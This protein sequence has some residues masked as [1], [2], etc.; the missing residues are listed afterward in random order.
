M[1]LK[2]IGGGLAG[3]EAA[4]QAA[5]RGVQV[6]LF[7]MRPHQ[8]T[9]AHRTGNLA[10]LV[11]SNSLGSNLTNRPAGL[12]KEEL[13]RLGSLLISSADASSLPAGGAL[14]VDRDLFA[15]II[16]EK[17]SSHPNITIVREEIREI[18]AAPAIIATGPL[19]SS[20]LAQSILKFTGEDQL[21]FYDAIAPVITRES[22][23]ME[24]AF[25]ANRYA[26]GDGGEGDYINCPL[27]KDQYLTFREALIH[28]KRIPLRE[29][30]KEIE[31]GV[32]A[33]EQ[34][35]FQA[36]QPIEVIAG[37]GE[38]ALAF[39]PLR[40]VGLFDPHSNNKRP[41]AVVQLRQEN[42]AGDL[43]N[44]VG[45]QTN[46]TYSEQAKVFKMIPGLENAAFERFGQ[47]HRNTYL[48]GPK[49]LDESLA[50]KNQPG[51]F[52]AGQ[53]AGFEGYA[54]N[55]AAGLIAGINATNYIKG[56]PLLK[57]PRTTMIGALVHYVTHAEA[58]NFQPT[59]AMFG[60]LPKPED[61]LRRKKI[62]RY[63]FYVERA[64]KH[65]EPYA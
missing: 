4:W 51:L 14:A 50:F 56:I 32:K 44:L 20:R 26:I 5:Q 64:L 13:R 59:K 63:D 54:G 21:Y 55:I 37:R 19:T 22:I 17:L 39:G 34:N 7:E 1:E 3:C 58:K 65:L 57:L 38:M 2:I 47:M 9:G 11:C 29:F 27:N 25:R 48:C 36:C 35:Y 42:L 10:E 31:D 45:F 16:E 12:L 18:P 33:G 43:Y 8:T 23:N 6:K 40:P 52:V 41:F 15:K 61:G 46:L 49:L 62:E 53:L 24:V 30:E 60:L 28:A